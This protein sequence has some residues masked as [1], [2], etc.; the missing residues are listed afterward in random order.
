MN[1]SP[2]QL[3]KLLNHCSQK[4]IPDRLYAAAVVFVLHVL[5]A[6]FREN[7]IARC[8]SVANLVWIEIQ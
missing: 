7:T 4:I 8:E 2:N 6:C 3:P 1:P 5:V